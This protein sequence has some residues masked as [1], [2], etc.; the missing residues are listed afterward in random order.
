MSLSNL[1]EIAKDRETW[2]SVVDGATETWIWLSEKQ[3]TKWGRA[4]PPGGPV[5]KTQ[6]SQ[7]R[8]PG[9]NPWSGN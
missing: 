3:Q 8:G 5:A 1:Q 4:C 2:R 9:F 7:C 6:H